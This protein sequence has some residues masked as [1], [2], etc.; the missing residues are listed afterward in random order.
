[1]M[2]FLSLGKGSTVCCTR[3]L[4]PAQSK[5]ERGL[6]TPAVGRNTRLRSISTALVSEKIPAAISA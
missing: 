5:S 3:M 2:T 4:W 1:M 6:V